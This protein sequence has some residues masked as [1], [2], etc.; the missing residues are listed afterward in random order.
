MSLQPQPV[1]PVPLQTAQIAKAAFPKG[2]TFM[3]L[4]D[5]LGTLFTDEDFAQLFASR[6]QTALSPWQLAFVTLMQF[7]EGLVTP[8]VLG[9][10]EQTG[11][12]QSFEVIKARG[13]TGRIATPSPVADWQ[14]IVCEAAFCTIGEPANSQLESR[15]DFSKVASL[16]KM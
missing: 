16:T 11:Y 12:D 6:R 7:A 3:L 2:N 15:R 10:L 1:N 8:T 14:D 9:A 5:E 13:G 4:R